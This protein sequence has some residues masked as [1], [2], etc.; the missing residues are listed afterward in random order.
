MVSKEVRVTTRGGARPGAGRKP[1]SRN[2]RT[3]LTEVLPRL[4]EPD[5][6]LPLYRLLAQ[7]ED[8]TEDIRYRDALS[9]ACLPYLHPRPVSNLTAKPPHLMSDEELKAT[10]H[11]EIEH[12][13]QL[14]KG[15]E[16]SRIGRKK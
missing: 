3:V 8:E 7:I 13:R 14:A 6:Q 15:R 9:I 11:A 16:H 1:G 12:Q 4:A 10:R 5:R 2:R